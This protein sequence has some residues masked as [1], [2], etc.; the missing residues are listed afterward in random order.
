MRITF[1]TSSAQ[2]VA[3][4]LAIRLAITEPS[5]HPASKMAVGG[6]LRE[7]VRP[8]IKGCPRVGRVRPVRSVGLSVGPVRFR[9]PPC[10][11]F[12]WWYVPSTVRHVTPSLRH[13]G[14]LVLRGL[15]LVVTG[16]AESLAGPGVLTY[17]IATVSGLRTC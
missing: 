3:V 15:Q 16:F 1:G 7:D 2:Q 6:K 13:P 10:A 8:N 9:R 17:A 4:P 14:L 11:L 12:G 5:Q